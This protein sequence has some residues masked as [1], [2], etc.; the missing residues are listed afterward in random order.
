MVMTKESY[1]PLSNYHKSDPICYWGAVSS[2]TP[3]ISLIL[4]KMSARLIDQKPRLG[5]TLGK[6]FET[7]IWFMMAR[8][9]DPYVKV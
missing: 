3:F 9:W 8:S 1:V 4:R 7:P 5:F 2:A 6:H